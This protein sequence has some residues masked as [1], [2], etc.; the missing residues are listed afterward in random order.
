[1][2]LIF[3]RIQFQQERFSLKTGASSG[4]RKVYWLIFSVGLYRTL[5]DSVQI[6]NNKLA[7]QVQ[8]S[9]VIYIDFILF[10]LT[11]AES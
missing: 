3:L 11:A 2:G 9:P 10:F 4:R 8:S 5:L 6:Q 7:N 1:M